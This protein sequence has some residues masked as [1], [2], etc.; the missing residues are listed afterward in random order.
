MK[1]RKKPSVRRP[2]CRLRDKVIFIDVFFRDAGPRADVQRTGGENS[3]ETQSRFS[4]D[5]FACNVIL[6]S[7]FK[8]TAVS[9]SIRYI[10]RIDTADR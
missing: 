6:Y 9:F 4:R 5:N 2:E 8:N 1:R 10:N 7:N 3:I